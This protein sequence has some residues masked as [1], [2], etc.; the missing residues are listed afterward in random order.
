MTVTGT[1]GNLWRTATFDLSIE[2]AL[3][4]SL[5]LSTPTTAEIVKNVS[6]TTA[7]VLANYNSGANEFVFIAPASNPSGIGISIASPPNGCRPKPSGCSVKVT[8]SA[9]SS[10]VP[11]DYN[12]AFNGL[13]DQSNAAAVSSAFTL[14]VRDPIAYTLSAN[15]TSGGVFQGNSSNVTIIATRQSGASETIRFSSFSSISNPSLFTDP[16]SG[17]QKVPAQGVIS[18]DFASTDCGPISAATTTCSRVASISVSSAVTPG[19]YRITMPARSLISNQA[20]TVTYDLA[21]SGPFDFA[22]SY[23]SPPCASATDCSGS[24]E[25]GGVLSIPVNLITSN[26]VGE[27]VHVTVAGLPTGTTV[28]DADCAPTASAPC[29]LNLNVNVLDSTNIGTYMLNIEGK[30]SKKQY[31]LSYSLEI[32]QG[33]AFTLSLSPSSGTA[34]KGGSSIYTLANISLTA[35]TATTTK[36]SVSAP[37]SGV[38]YSFPSGNDECI[39]TCQK[40][41]IFKASASAAT[42]TYPITIEARAGTL[43]PR[44]ENFILTV[45]DPFDF[46]MALSGYEGILAQNAATTTLTYATSTWR[47]GGPDNISYS[48]SVF[49]TPTSGAINI[50]FSPTACSGVSST[51]SD[52]ATAV[53]FHIDSSVPSDVYNITITGMG[54]GKMKNKNFLLIAGD[55]F[56]FGFQ[57][58][59]DS[60]RLMQGTSTTTVATITASSTPAQSVSFALG[61]SPD[62]KAPGWLNVA[63]PAACTP[64]PI[65]LL[66][67][68]CVS[69]Q[70]TFNA[71]SYAPNG[72]YSIPIAAV[73][74]YVRKIIYYNL[75]VGPLELKPYE[76]L[77]ETE[78]HQRP[79]ITAITKDKP[80]PFAGEIVM[81][82]PVAEVYTGEANREADTL[83]SG[84][85]A[86]FLWQFS[87]TTLESGTFPSS[88]SAWTPQ[89]KFPRSGN[90]NIS[91]T[92]RDNTGNICGPNGNE[93]CECP[94]DYFLKT[95]SSFNVSKPR[96]SFKEIKP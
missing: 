90:F 49:P 21:V 58:S 34:I 35:G 57:L 95:G 81:F 12:I 40:Q 82:T 18:V 23:D 6:T 31:F 2:Q 66:G 71:Q 51:S 93:R 76:Y 20:A 88:S 56:N 46:T 5:S 42:G 24:V 15:P 89:I 36:I 28:P 74:G 26:A 73:S 85:N 86:E 94:F 10:A 84:S 80:T 4:Y 68:T 27:N 67:A 48:A 61:D 22:L 53:S 55:P 75:K 37:P 65:D 30:S 8:F 3:S 87:T 1:T 13:S 64:S 38:T 47:Q 39:P 25:Q 54:G 96:P 63:L 50:E 72:T 52:C 43:T 78:D 59:K 83:V 77:F 45:S 29:N 79:Q 91:L 17:A 92:V 62:Y 11:G 16:D 60:A 44:T 69:G 33:F 32:R 19:S 7:Y 41:I 14:Q 70:I 9:D